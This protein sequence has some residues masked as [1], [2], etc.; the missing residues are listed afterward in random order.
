MIWAPYLFSLPHEQ[1]FLLALSNIF[2]ALSDLCLIL[3]YQKIDH[4]VS[5]TI[6]TIL[7]TLFCVFE[8]AYTKIVCGTDFCI[9]SC[10]PAIFL[11][12]TSK[13]PSQKYFFS[14]TLFFT[15]CLAYVIHIKITNSM[16]R[17]LLNFT[18]RM[19]VVSSNVFYTIITLFF[20]L[21]TCFTTHTIFRKLRLKQTVLHKKLSNLAK[22]DPLTGLMNRRRTHEIFDLCTNKK[23][24]D[25]TEYAIAI[26][27]I[28][29][30]KKIND[31]YGH[32]A[33]DWILKSFT[34]NLWN[35]LPAPIKIGRWG[36]EEF[37]IIFPTI[38]N[39]TIYNFE[40]VRR[41]IVEK[42][43]IYQNMK[44]PVTATFGI[45]SSRQANSPEEVLN[46]ADK[47]LLTGKTNGKNRIVVSEKF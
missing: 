1:F 45:S 43:I 20:L 23:I 24:A 44:I 36:G 17:P 41:R 6:F 10:I 33:G 8:S 3:F 16:T 7:L 26:A 13:R 32:D 35:L 12:T 46:D 37:I 27:D 38:N 4:A 9:V 39:N 28:D 18:L 34:R 30:F 14:M 40:Q 11:Y 19:F 25:G 5:V 22:H 29:D 31:T 47:M 42:P 15:L 21:Y 2:V